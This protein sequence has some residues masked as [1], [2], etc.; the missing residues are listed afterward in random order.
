LKYY[1]NGTL[2]WSGTDSTLKTGT[3]GFG[4]YRDSYTGTLDVD[5]AKLTV[6]VTATLDFD[7][8]EMVITG[9]EMPGGSIDMSPR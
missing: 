9:E 3:V 1:I 2:V 8:S 4:F 7:P 5:W 6:P